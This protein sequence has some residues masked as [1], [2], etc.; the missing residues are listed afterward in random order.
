MKKTISALTILAALLLSLSACGT[1]RTA[2]PETPAA[3]AQVTAEAQAPAE[4]A[5]PTEAAETAEPAPAG[6]QDGERFEAVVMLEGMEETVGLEHAVSETIG[7]ALDYEYEALDRRTEADRECFVSHYEDPEDPWNY[8]EIRYDTGN[9]ELVASA[10]KATL[11]GVYDTVTLEEDVLDRA[12]ACLRVDASG[13]GDDSV[14]AGSLQ[15][16]Y[17]IPAGDGCLVAAAHCTWE[18]A[19]GFGATFSQ[20]MN[21]LSLIERRG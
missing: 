16:V 13:A 6:R 3:E 9:A 8:L 7:F 20:I 19:E 10:V 4:E 12:G 17:I 5:D 2:E 14:P 15:T 11:S 18:S 21:T 1:P